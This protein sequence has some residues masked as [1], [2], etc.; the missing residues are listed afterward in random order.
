MKY[1]QNPFSNLWSKL[2]SLPGFI[3]FLKE[4]VTNIQALE[5]P[6]TDTFV[7]ENEYIHISDWVEPSVYFTV[8]C[9]HQCRQ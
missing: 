9:P 8:F 4:E 5:E 6:V 1:Q 2:A 3:Y 7:D